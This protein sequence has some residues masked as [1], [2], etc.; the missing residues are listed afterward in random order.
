MFGLFKRGIEHYE[1]DLTNLSPK[2][3]KNAA[4]GLGNVKDERA[5]ALLA[6]ALQD[7]EAEV[8][9]AATHALGRVGSTSAVGPLVRALEGP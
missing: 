2:K 7:L 4:R 9:E 8:R 1:R 6:S 5:V 3:R